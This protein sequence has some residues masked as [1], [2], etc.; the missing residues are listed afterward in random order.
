MTDSFNTS[1][2]AALADLGFEVDDRLTGVA[3]VEGPMVIHAV[4]HGEWHYKLIVILPNGAEIAGFV[5]R[6][7][8]VAATG[9]DVISHRPDVHRW[10]WH[11]RLATPPGASA[12]CMRFAWKPA[13]LCRRPS[14][15]MSCRI[16]AITPCSGSASSAPYALTATIASTGTMPQGCQSALM[17]RQATRATDGT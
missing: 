15:I 3:R 13:A 7:R 12:A 1:D 6:S 11:R 10:Y 16:K 2:R 5:P 9:E 4:P 14:P 8:I 17:V